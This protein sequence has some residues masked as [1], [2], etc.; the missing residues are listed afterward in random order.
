MLDFFYSIA[1]F[2]FRQKRIPNLISP[3]R[4][5]DKILLIKLR[6][7]SLTSELRKIVSDRLAV[8]DYIS[9]K[10]TD[11]KLINILWKGHS[12]TLPEWDELPNKFVIKATHGSQ[13][14]K[15]VNK[16]VDS[17][18]DVC[19][20]SS[21]WLKLDYYRKGRE[22]VYK[23]TPRQLIV[24]EFIEFLGDVPPDYKFFCLN[25]KVQLIQVDLDRFSTHR[26]NMYSPSFKLL[27]VKFL[28][29]NGEGVSEPKLFSNA[30]EIAEK[31]SEDFDFIRVDLYVLDNQIYFGELTNFPENTLGKFSSNDFDNK[32]GS[33]LVLDEK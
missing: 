17:Y 11:C 12:L 30:K 31:L 23:D 19:K 22:W 28:Y 14:V 21:S 1:I 20:I 3:K 16:D 2:I 33:L 10:N 26:R 7:N 8:R 18:S 29:E 6:E 25:G 5:T 32:I 13:M 4:L 9:S 24:E 15:I 27:D